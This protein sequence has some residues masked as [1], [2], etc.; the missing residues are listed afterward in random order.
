MLPTDMLT[1]RRTRM[2]IGFDEKQMA[3]LLL[4]D[5][6]EDYHRLENGDDEITQHL[7]MLIRN[8][9][10]GIELK[11]AGFPKCTVLGS[12]NREDI[13]FEALTTISHNH[14]PRFLAQVVLNSDSADG[15]LT[16]PVTKFE[17]MVLCAWIDLPLGFNQLQI[18]MLL[19]DT[20]SEIANY[21]IWLE[22]Q[23]D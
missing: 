11:E 21:F 12:I 23:C 4:I 3:T 7:A 17:K 6:V 20:A 16:V 15:A 1:L 19:E 8:I 5:S 13:S 14:F 22:Q 9:R 2:Q 10:T 18:D